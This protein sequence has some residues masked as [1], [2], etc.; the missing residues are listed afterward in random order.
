MKMISADALRD[1]VQ[2]IFVAAGASAENAYTVANS[3]VGANL[4]GHESHGVI[5]T[6]RYLQAIETGDVVLDAAPS[7]AADN[8]ATVTVDGGSTFGQVSAKFSAEL[9]N[10]RAREHGIAAV[11]LFNSY[12]IGRVGEWVEMVANQNLAALAFCNV[13]SERPWVAPHGGMQRFLGTNP[14]AAAVPIAGRDPFLLDYATSVVAEGKVKVAT[15]A[16]KPIP[17]HWVLNADGVPTTNPNDLYK[18]GMLNSAGAYK[19]FALGML[20]ELLGGVL[21]G[22]GWPTLPEGK[23]LRNGLFLIVLDIDRFRPIGDFLADS[24]TLY[25]NAKVVKPAPNFDEVLVPG[26]PE[27]RKSAERNEKGVPLDDGTWQLLVDAANPLQVPVPDLGVN[28]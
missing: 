4:S 6:P 9:A 20:V 17:E 18:G 23:R 22:S 26:E 21:T 14:F 11:S 7:I 25:E 28:E 12:H 24:A 10:E 13:A 3:L 19:G 15:V 8:G 1:F 5:R 2:Q 16:E 27:A